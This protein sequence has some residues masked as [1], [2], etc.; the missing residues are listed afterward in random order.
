VAREILDA[1][2]SFDRLSTS[3]SVIETLKNALAVAGHQYF[4]LNLFPRPGQT[5][6]DAIMAYELPPAWLELYLR[7]SFVEFDPSIR[8]CKK[9]L[10]PFAYLDA[11]YD[12]EGDICAAEVMNRAR[13]F[14]VCNGTVVPIPSLRGCVGDLWVG[15]ADGSIE[16][17]ELPCIHMLALCAF[18][19][20]Q[21]LVHPAEAKSALSDR[22]REVLTWVANGKTAW[23]IG[24]VLNISRRTVEWHIQQAVEKLGAKNRVQAVVIAAR[25]HLIEI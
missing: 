10:L 16:K 4:C 3:Q 13:D 25:D 20:I 7:R 23:E 12:T 8:H 6:L 9:V 17:A 19:K 2:E 24:E 14:G 5:F 21:Q 18:H 11:P 15:G 1:I 22:E